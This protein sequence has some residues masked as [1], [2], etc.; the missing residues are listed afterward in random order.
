MLSKCANPDCLVSS[1]EDARFYRFPRH[2]EP[3]QPAANP[4]SV[5]HFWLCRACSEIY[6]LEYHRQRGI[7]M[8]PRPGQRPVLA[9]ARI[10]GSR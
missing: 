1:W 9:L 4:H 6:T 7:L 10:A 8:R 3:N 5:Q 2:R